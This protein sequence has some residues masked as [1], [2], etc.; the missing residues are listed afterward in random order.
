M[1][2][3]RKR[4]IRRGLKSPVVAAI[5]SAVATASVVGGVAMAQTSAS[6]V[7]TACV[8]ESNGNVRIV[9]NASDCK[10]NERLTT[11]NQQGP[12]GLPGPP[13]PARFVTTL[14]NYENQVDCVRQGEGFNECARVTVHVPANTTYVAGINSAGSFA[15]PIDDEVSICPSARRATDTSEGG[16]YCNTLSSGTE[17]TGNRLS[18]VASNAVATLTGGPSGTDWIISTAVWSVK[19]LSFAPRATINTLVALSEVE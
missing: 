10:A 3:R 16:H 1:I 11:W 5:V 13:G 19:P 9:S 18:S 4:I 6:A 12:Q 8:A 2:T 14:H 17:L 7:I 15:S